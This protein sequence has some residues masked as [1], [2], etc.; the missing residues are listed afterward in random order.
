M[1][2]SEL[3][4]EI[5]SALINEETLTEMLGNA[6][7]SIYHLQA[8]AGEITRYPILVYSPISDVPIMHGDDLESAYRVTIRIHIITKNG[9]YSEINLIIN[10]IMTMQLGYSRVQTTPYVE[11]DK[12]MLICDYR[13]AVKN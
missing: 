11:E 8:P 2:T 7:E 12:K 3:E 6:K 4:S 1:T 9:E 13:I 5:Y 10:R